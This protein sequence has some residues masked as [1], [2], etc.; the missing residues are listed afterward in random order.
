MSESEYKQWSDSITS[1]GECDVCG[2]RQRLRA[3]RLWDA[4][5]RCGDG[6][7]VC[8]FCQLAFNTW[9][10]E[11]IQ[12]PPERVHYEQWK[13]AYPLKRGYRFVTNEGKTKVR[14]KTK[15]TLTDFDRFTPQMR[16]VARTYLRTNE[17]VDDMLQDIAIRIVANEYMTISPKGWLLQATRWRCS[18]ILDG[19]KRIK[20]ISLDEPFNV[21]D[22]RENN[23]NNVTDR[24][25]IKRWNDAQVSL[26][27]ELSDEMIAALEQLSERQRQAFLL[28]AVEGASHREIA[29]ELGCSEGA[30]QQYVFRAKTNLQRILTNF[31]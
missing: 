22:D 25:S 18:Q 24:L 16:D 13:E 5:G 21:G 29:E 4:L 2:D 17:D 23:E 3:Q 20:T 28:F 11:V 10:S 31:E 15:V 30:S 7:C 8:Q 9:C 1:V 6:V 14:K 19:R 26:S 27:D 12:G